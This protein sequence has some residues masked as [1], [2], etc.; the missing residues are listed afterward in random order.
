MRIA[1]SFTEAYEDR[2]R[3][4]VV[5]VP[6][7]WTWTW[8]VGI[9]LLLIAL[10]TARFEAAGGDPTGLGGIGIAC[11]L[12]GLFC[13]FIIDL[14]GAILALRDFDESEGGPHD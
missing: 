3:E 9:S 4:I 10:A 12:L 14:S 6:K 8:R 13:P 1:Q 2:N 7:V 11:I 5:L